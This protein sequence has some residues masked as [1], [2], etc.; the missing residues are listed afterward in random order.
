MAKIRYK[1]PGAPGLAWQSD[2]QTLQI[3]FAEPR[4]AITPG[5]SVVLYEGE[6]V[7]AGGWIHEV[8]VPEPA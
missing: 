7:L 4:H 5:Q 3:A 1:D 8:G 6:D 2:A